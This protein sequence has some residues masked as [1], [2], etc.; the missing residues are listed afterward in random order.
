MVEQ[1]DP[2]LDPDINK[3][4]T[5]GLFRVYKDPKLDN[6]FASLGKLHAAHKI[7]S[8]LSRKIFEPG[9]TIFCSVGRTESMKLDELCQFHQTDFGYSSE[10]YVAIYSTQLTNNL[11]EETKILTAATKRLAV[12]AIVIAVLLGLLQAGI[13]LLQVQTSSPQFVQKVIHRISSLFYCQ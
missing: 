11:A 8:K 5:C 4:V 7:N 1:L 12:I 13:G 10:H 2:N 6:L 3:C 9:P